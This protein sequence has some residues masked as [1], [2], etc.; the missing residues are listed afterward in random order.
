MVWGRFVDQVPV[1]FVD[2]AFE[3]YV[4]ARLEFCSAWAAGGFCML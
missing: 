3:E 2:F 1:L 4:I